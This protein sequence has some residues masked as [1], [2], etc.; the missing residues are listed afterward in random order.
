MKLWIDD[1]RPA[2]EGYVWLR[3]VHEAKWLIKYYEEVLDG[4]Y[5]MNPNLPNKEAVEFFTLHIIDIDTDAGVCV[6][7][8]GDYITLLGWLEETGRNY[9]I[10]IHGANAVGVANMRR[11]IQ[12]NNWKEVF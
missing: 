12:R 2:P 10:R 9:P 11:V 4:A 8:G 5:R 3:T 1:L 7:D 6:G